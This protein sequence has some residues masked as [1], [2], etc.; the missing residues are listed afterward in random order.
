MVTFCNIME[1]YYKT[2]INIYYLGTEK[3]YSNL[4]LII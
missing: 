2:K 4:S 1:L 3:Y